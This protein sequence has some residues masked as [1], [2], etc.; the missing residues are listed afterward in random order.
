MGRPHKTFGIPGAASRGR[1]R[2]RFVKTLDR[3]AAGA[4]DRTGASS[5]EDRFT[6][7]KLAGEIDGMV[8]AGSSTWEG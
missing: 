4:G 5:L 6:E 8:L 1:G 7:S 2:G 3:D